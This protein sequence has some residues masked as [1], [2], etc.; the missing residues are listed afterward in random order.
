MGFGNYNGYYQPGYY[1]PGNAPDLLGQFKSQYPSFGAPPSGG[2]DMLWVLGEVEA[3]SYP[4]A[5]NNTVVLWDKDRTT[6]YIKSANAQGVPSIRVLDYEERKSA[7][8]EHVCSCG[9]KF[10]DR[11]AFEALEAK[12]AALEARLGNVTKEGDA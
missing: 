1:T 6:V 3:Q 5:P 4:V 9:D 8:T 10:V 2:N 12:F 7:P 11:K